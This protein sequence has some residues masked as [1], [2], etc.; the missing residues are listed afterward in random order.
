MSPVRKTIID[1]EANIALYSFFLEHLESYMK[2][3]KRLAHYFSPAHPEGLVFRS[4]LDYHKLRGLREE[5]L[6]GIADRV[7]AIAL[8]KDNVVSSYE[9]QNTLKGADRDIP[10]NV[11]VMDPPYH[12]SHENPFPLNKNIAGQ[13]DEAFDE[14]FGIA[15]NFL[16]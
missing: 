12:Y 14:I 4:M 6:R 13:V 15:G 2:I 9:V 11:R 5:K 8:K 16:K 3:D 10:I 1:S 7:G